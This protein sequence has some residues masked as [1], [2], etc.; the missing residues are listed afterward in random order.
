M[1]NFD[2]T[3][4][5]HYITEVKEEMLYEINWDKVETFEDFVALAK[6]GAIRTV[7]KHESTYKALDKELKK[8]YKAT[9]TSILR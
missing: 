7:Q 3:K 9:G 8:Y 4:T 5:G 2:S 6:S 1:E